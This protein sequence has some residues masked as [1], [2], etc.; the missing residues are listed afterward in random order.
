M[1]ADA[2]PTLNRLIARSVAKKAQSLPKIAMCADLLQLFLILFPCVSEPNQSRECSEGVP[3]N[4]GAVLQT[5]ITIASAVP[6]CS[7]K[8]MPLHSQISDQR[9]RS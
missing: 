5:E 3:C 6:N 9:K 1:L 7:K 2:K 4:S 8:I